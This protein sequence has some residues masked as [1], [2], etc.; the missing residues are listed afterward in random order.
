MHNQLSSQAD[1]VQPVAWNHLTCQHEGWHALIF[2]CWL[3]SCSWLAAGWHLGAEMHVAQVQGLSTDGLQTTHQ[4]SCVQS[5]LESGPS[6]HRADKLLGRLS[7]H[8]TKGCVCTPATP[9][10]ALM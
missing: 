1:E 9:I 7:L 6:L 8:M 2:I 5:A 4:W 10:P 3:V